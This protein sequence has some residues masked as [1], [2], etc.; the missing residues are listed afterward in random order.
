MKVISKWIKKLKKFAKN[1]KGFSLFELMVAVSIT[2][3]VATMSAE[4]MDSVLPM[5]RD[6]QRKANIHQVATALH[7]YY[8]DHGAY[9]VSSSQE[10]TAAGWL[11]MKASLEGTDPLESYMPEVPVDPL[12]DDAHKFEYSSDGEKFRI[13]YETEDTTDASPQTVYGL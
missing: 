5:A 10:P 9:P 11:E 2:S 1:R 13:A 4:Q 6:A 7:L 8:N 3:M 12:N